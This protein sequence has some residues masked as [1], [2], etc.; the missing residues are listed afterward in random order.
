[1]A[2]EISKADILKILLGER[3]ETMFIKKK[4]TGDDTS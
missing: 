2:K 4:S 1:M 3:E